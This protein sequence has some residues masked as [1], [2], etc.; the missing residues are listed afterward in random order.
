V[1]RITVT[2]ETKSAKMG[3]PRCFREE[4]ALDA[5]MR[6]FWDKGYEGASLDDL[7][8]AMGINRSSLYATFGDKEELFEKVMSRYCEGP[9][10]YM[11]EALQQPTARQVIETILRKTVK[12]LADP[13]NPRGCLLLQG[14]LACGSD[15]EAARQAMIEH[16]TAGF[17]GIQKRMHRA[18]ADGD[19]PKDVNPT[20]LAR[21]VTIVLNGLS[22]Q[23]VNGAT[24]SEMKRAVAMAL[25]SMPV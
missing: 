21:Y 14:G 19:L 6:V 23:A 5:A 8:E 4:E 15:A 24:P 10:A 7:T 12:A 3:R 11:A 1:H 9:M 16:R 13:E 25:R 18:Q 22:I 2:T 20:D 17:R